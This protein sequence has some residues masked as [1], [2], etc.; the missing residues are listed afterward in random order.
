MYREMKPLFKQ[1]FK[2]KERGVTLIE[3]LVAMSILAMVSFT[4][5]SGLTTSSTAVIVSRERVAVE[6]LARSQMEYVKNQE[7]DDVNDP[8]Q[9]DK[10]PEED[11]LDGYDTGVSAVRLDPSVDGGG[12]DYGLQEITVEIYQDVEADPILTMVDYKFKR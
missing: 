8:P 3:T 2:G 6:S 5:L 12:Y 11:I 10:L 7:Y 1:I 9:Y 4:F